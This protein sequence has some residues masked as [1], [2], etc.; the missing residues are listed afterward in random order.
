[1]IFNINVLKIILKYKKINFKKQIKFLTADLSRILTPLIPRVNLHSQA[2]INL[3]SD[4][5]GPL[6][7][8]DNL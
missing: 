1:L 6:G 5:I 8:G 3:Y 4:L 7:P 2:Q